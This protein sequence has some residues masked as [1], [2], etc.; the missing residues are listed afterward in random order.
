VRCTAHRTNAD[1]HRVGIVKH[2]WIVRE[3]E[4]SL[5]QRDIGWCST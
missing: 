1:Q 3:I 2:V 4:A 5:D